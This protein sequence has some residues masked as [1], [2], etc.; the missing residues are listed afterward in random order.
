VKK[1]D[2]VRLA[3][4]AQIPPLDADAAGGEGATGKRTVFRLMLK[5]FIEGFA[6]CGAS[7]YPAGYV[8]SDNSSANRR[9]AQEVGVADWPADDTLSYN[10]II[11]RMETPRR[12]LPGSRSRWGFR[13]NKR[14]F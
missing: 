14:E 4:T 13:R 6:Q 3:A 10:D 9:N 8:I 12:A 2:A 11:A 5:I 1:F 7:M